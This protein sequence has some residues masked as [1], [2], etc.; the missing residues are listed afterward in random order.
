[1]LDIFGSN[2]GWYRLFDSRG[3]GMNLTQ[4]L[5]S[6]FTYENTT[7]EWQRG[8][9]DCRN[10]NEPLSDG[11]RYQQGYQY[12]YELGEKQCQR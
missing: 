2:R 7:T 10:H 11:E 6:V 4:Q 8:F 5:E 12:A 9:Q 1:M 3:D